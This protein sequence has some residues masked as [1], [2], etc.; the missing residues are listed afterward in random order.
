[1]LTGVPLKLS[2]SSFGFILV[3]MAT[4]NMIMIYLGLIPLLFVVAALFIEAPRQFS[5]E[6]Q[7]ESVSVEVDDELSVTRR[8]HVGEGWGL[9]TLGEELPSSFELVEGNNFQAFWKNRGDAEVELKYTVKCT[10]R[11]TYQLDKVNWEARHPMSMTPTM[12]GVFP[13]KQELIVKPRSLR[14]KRIRQQKIFTKIP[15]PAESRIKIG[16]PTSD[17]K[18][19]REYHF[20]DSYKQINWKATARNFK[21]ANMLPTVNEYEKEGRRLVFVFLDTSPSLGLGT[22]LRNSFEYAVQAVLGLS[23]FYISRQCKL[24]VSLYNSGSAEAGKPRTYLRGERLIGDQQGLV[25]TGE[26]SE[27]PRLGKGVLLFPETGKI[28]Q[29]RV[30]QMMLETEMGSTS[31][32]LHNSVGYVKGHLHG[33]NPLFTIVTRV[34]DGNF[35]SLVSGVQEL[36]KYT[37]KSRRQRSNIMVV[38][39]SGYSLTIR[40]RGDKTAAQLLEHQENAYLNRLRSLGIMAVNWQPTRQ[41]IT[42]VLLAQVGNR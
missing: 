19:L 23:E 42:E 17:F 20:G 11:G 10:R 30:H 7:E 36:T 3:G 28:Q 6:A 2:L 29:Y 4:G 1:M 21:G 38:N 41:S 12:T 37:R 14:I 39:V 13:L 34:H 9:V 8:V 5:M 40:K 26:E 24:G 35:G 32:S 18:E 31:Y 15:M 33:S 22:D 27:P 25:V 16:V